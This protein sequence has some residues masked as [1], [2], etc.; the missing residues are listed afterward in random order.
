MP[1]RAVWLTP[2]LDRGCCFPL[3][4]KPIYRRGQCALVAPNN[5]ALPCY[6]T[7]NAQKAPAR[8]SG[9]IQMSETIVTQCEIVRELNQSDREVINK[10]AY[11][12]KSR[13]WLLG[14]AQVSLELRSIIRRHAST[15]AVCLKEDQSTSPEVDTAKTT[16]LDNLTVDIRGCKSF[17]E[18]RSL[19]CRSWLSRNACRGSRQDAE[20]SSPSKVWLPFLTTSQ[21]A[22]TQ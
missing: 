22:V 14:Y 17:C 19:P 4:D 16:D 8:A 18:L 13:H 15:C 6:Y 7:H 21:P 10:A 3:R 1:T 9:E 12:W 11:D 2:K 20:L 5:Q